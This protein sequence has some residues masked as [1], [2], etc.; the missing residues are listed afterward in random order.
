M[1]A[2]VGRHSD[3]LALLSKAQSV[4]REMGIQRWGEGLE[5]EQKLQESIDAE[6]AYQEG[7]K[8]FEDGRIDEA[9][10]RVE[11]AAQITGM[12]RYSEKAQEFRQVKATIRGIHENL[13]SPQA[14]PGRVAQ[15]KSDLEILSAQYGEN[16][17]LEKIKPRLQAATPR[18]IAPLKDQ[19]RIQKTQAEQAV[20]LGESLALAQ[21]A[22]THLD[23]IRD[24]GGMD[25]ELSQL[26]GEVDQLLR[27]VQRYENELNLADK[28][29]E[30][31]KNWPAQASRLSEGVRRRYPDDP[32]VA[33]LNRSLA[34]Y[35]MTTPGNSF[36]ATGRR[37]R[38]HWA[39]W[40]VRSQPGTG[41]H[42]LAYPHC[43]R[44]PDGYFHTDIH[45][46]THHNC[47]NNPNPNKHRDPHTHTGGGHH[48]P[49]C[50]GARRL[51]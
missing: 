47:Y 15:A 7:L 5:F 34:R 33:Q 23:Q 19:A 28:A 39:N 4:M 13:S 27:D 10:E 35:H 48:L 30:S 24:L 18:V 51:L 37:D 50:L 32:R 9:I 25:D 44:N 14:D 43:H 31:N 16:P 46:H 11:A 8:F 12:P 49:G 40:P 45:P 38:D 29:Y 21:G 22:R 6:N 41:L 26:A 3:A 17:A 2:R 42:D 36:R 20:T 1:P